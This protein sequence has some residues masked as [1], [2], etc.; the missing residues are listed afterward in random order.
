MHKAAPVLGLRPRDPRHDRARRL[1][2]AVSGQQTEGPPDAE[3]REGN[4]VKPPAEDPGAH[5][6]FDEEAHVHSVQWLL[7]RNRGAF[8]AA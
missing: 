1:G 7:S 4:L 5:G 2:T 3:N 6:P 8:S